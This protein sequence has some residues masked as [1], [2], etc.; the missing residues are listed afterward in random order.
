[1]VIFRHLSFVAPVTA[2]PSASSGGLASIVLFDS[3]DV[4][5]PAC[6]PVGSVDGGWRC[7]RVEGSLPGR[8]IS[9]VGALPEQVFSCN[10]SL[11]GR[12]F[13]RAVQDN[14]W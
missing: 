1:L 12:A 4:R 3:G 11:L 7:G 10:G 5:S 9:L 6:S 8:V 2:V 14:I 13:Q